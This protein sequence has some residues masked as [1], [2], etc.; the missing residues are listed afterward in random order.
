[1][2]ALLWLP[3][4]Y[5]V[6]RPKGTRRLGLNLTFACSRRD[7]LPSLLGGGG[8]AHWVQNWTS[9]GAEVHQPM[10]KRVT[11]MP[12]LKNARQLDCRATMGFAPGCVGQDE[13]RC[14]TLD[15]SPTLVSAGD[16]LHPTHSSGH[17]VEQ[18]QGRY[19]GPF[20]NSQNFGKR[21]DS[22]VTK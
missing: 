20:Q 4:A 3:P 7:G 18:P 17:R 8:G 15:L 14:C 6:R 19:M 13:R 1:M 12:T 11:Y 16:T 5:G 21:R 2:P 10:A 22:Y 9:Q